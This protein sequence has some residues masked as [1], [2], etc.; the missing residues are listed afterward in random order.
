MEWLLKNPFKLLIK[1]KETFTLKNKG[2]LLA[3][4]VPWRTFNIRGI[5]PFHKR[6][7]VEKGLLDY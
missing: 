2:S 7:Y 3:S 5:F 6:L 4:M 1:S